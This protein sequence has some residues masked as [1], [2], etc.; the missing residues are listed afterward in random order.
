MTVKDFSK[1]LN[2]KYLSNE[3]KAAEREINGC[4]CG[5]LLSWV[6]S[7]AKEDNIWLTVMGNINSI[8][9]AV[10]TDVSCI[11]LTENAPLDDNAKEK[12]EQNGVIILTTD[13]TSYEVAAEFSKIQ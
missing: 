4:Y 8:G 12:A 7:R 5:D 1:K 2:L 3:A 9:V 13:K 10:L 11:V 6:M